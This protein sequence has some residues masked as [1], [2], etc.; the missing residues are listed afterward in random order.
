MSHLSVLVLICARGSIVLFTATL[1]LTQ[2]RLR[3]RILA[4]VLMGLTWPLSL[5]AFLF[6]ASL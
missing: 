6:A 2:D 1:L 4:A 3:Y 5:V